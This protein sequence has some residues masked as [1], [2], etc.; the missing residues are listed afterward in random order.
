MA[1]TTVRRDFEEVACL[2][3]DAKQERLL[4]E[5]P[6]YNQGCPGLFRIVQCRNCDLVYLNPRPSQKV[7]H[8]YYPP[9]EWIRVKL[10]VSLEKGEISGKPWRQI[11]ARRSSPIL[12]RR[13]RGRILEIGSGDGLFLRHL[14]EKGW[15]CVGVEPDPEA[16]QYAREVCGV[17]VQTG[18]PD[19]IDFP[20][21]SFD[22]TSL[23]AAI[24]HLPNPLETL[25]KLKGLIQEDGFIYI[26][27]VPN[28]D[29][30]DRRL[31]GKRWAHLNAPRHLY[32][33]TPQ[34]LNKVLE[35][36]GLFSEAVGMQSSEGKTVMGYTDSLRY[37]LRDMGLP[38]GRK[39]RPG[40]IS[41]EGGSGCWER[42]FSSKT[43]QTI[44]VLEYGIF[45]AIGQ[46][47][48]ACQKGSVFSVI[49]KKREGGFLKEER[50]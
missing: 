21:H 43:K 31:F 39:S 24:E 44:H 1:G 16:S 37:H 34:T 3:C 48:D 15:D 47:A 32:H 49:A 45:R 12:S 18:S 42:I 13:V 14:M 2:L 22:V 17:S 41:E 40:G 50:P 23:F 27:S 11:M 5:L 10:K 30:F 33:F 8:Q 29:S 25:K 19:T 9:E 38:V 36:I 20:P 7:I 28:F 26:G 46:I 4:F 35:R 6:D